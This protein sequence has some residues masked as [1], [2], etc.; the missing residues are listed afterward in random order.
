MNEQKDKYSK[1]RTLIVVCFWLILFLVLFSQRD[2]LTVENI[3]NYS[4]KNPLLAAVVVLALY[5][6][7]GF[8]ML[9]NGYI[10]YIAAGIMFSIPQALV[11]NFVG[12]IVMITIPFMLG[13]KGGAAAVEKL[14]AKYKKLATLRDKPNQNALSTT[15]LLRVLGILPCEIVSLYLG[16]CNLHFGKYLLGSMTGLLPSIIIFS[17]MGQYASSPGSPQFIIAVVVWII[18]I[19]AGFLL[20][21]KNKKKKEE[22][23][24]MRRFSRAQVLTIPN[25]LSLLRILLLPVIWVLYRQEQYLCAAWVVF[26]SGLTDIM[27]GKIARHYNMVSDFGKILDPVADKLTQGVLI[28]CL[29]MR[30]R[31]MIALV[32]MFAAYELCKLIMG[33]VT[34]RRYDS[35]NG[36]KWYGKATTVLLYAVSILLV[37]F[38]GIP[39]TAANV[40]ILLCKLVTT[41]SFLLYVLF[42]VKLWRSAKL[43]TE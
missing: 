13:R 39:V 20:S 41:L 26:L 27:D 34:M 40:M 28:L 38:P 8:S 16:A 33:Y 12:S 32:I 42:Y 25:A 30:Y 4:P 24:K 15:F 3:V 5:A 18:S 43:E 21:G 14:T 29:S 31:E 11:V 2:K 19:V 22:C 9:I 17:V 7:K 6:V 37:L 1:I 35:I 36:A 10:L 23:K